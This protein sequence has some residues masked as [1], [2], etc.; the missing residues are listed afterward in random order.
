RSVVD[1]VLEDAGALGKDLG[2]A[3]RQ[4]LEEYLDAVRAVE[5]QIQA[6]ER[7]KAKGAMPRVDLPDASPTDFPSRLRLMSDLLA[8]AFQTDTTR[9]ATFIYGLE[10]GAGVGGVSYRHLGV[11]EDHHS[12]THWDKATQAEST[13]KIALV[14]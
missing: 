9:V 4:K 5:R 11:N 8:L 13:R 6:I 3:D 2:K 10:N 1:H 12:L 14:D 7:D